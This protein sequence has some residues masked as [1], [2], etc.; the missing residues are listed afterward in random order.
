MIRCWIIFVQRIIKYMV[1]INDF[2]RAYS[3]AIQD[4]YAAIFAGA[5]L[6]MSCGFVDWKGLLC[7]L[8]KEIKL[9]VEKEH[10][11]VEVAQYYC[12]EKRG[13][14]EISQKILNYF[15][16]ETE[17]ESKENE[18]VRLLAELPIKTFWTTNY[19]H[20]IEDT[21]KKS[22]K[23]VDIK[24][25]TQSLATTLSGSDAIVY[26]MHGDYLNA[27][28][29]VI[30]KDDYECYNDTRQLFSTTLQGDLVSKTFLFIG[31]S[32]EDPNLNYILSRI[33]V[34]LDK[35][36]RT[37]YL[38]SK[39]INKNDYE[40]INDYVYAQN[41]Q[42]LK[43]HDLL[44]YGIETVLIDDYSEIPKILSDLKIM[45][46]CNNIFISGSAHKYG[47]KWEKTAPLF[48]RELVHALYK[49]D[50]KIIT[51][52]ARGIGSYVISSVL[53]E[54]QSSVIELEKHLMI[55]AFPYEDKSRSDY[56]KIIEGYRKG[57][58]KSAGIAIFMFGNKTINNNTVLADGVYKEYQIAKQSG[59]Y[60]IPIGSTGYM[61]K[62]IWSEVYSDINNYPYLKKHI[63]V[64]QECTEPHT[65]IDSIISILEE[66]RST[67]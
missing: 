20:L 30:I 19:D 13:R 49:K 42:E 33:R 40:K 43:M 5:G 45:N 34:L 60:I 21:L 14:N 1:T 9:D 39:K 29:C 57:I 38:F 22:G 31:F 56:D 7:D 8:A 66:I 35:N 25:T 3:K 36:R 63:S 47:V 28:E 54:C 18:N 27:S 52:H 65:V 62:Q 2:K 24:M 50:Y 17:S 32:F 41:K 12:N 55:K 59:A 64:L 37:H 4:G 26:K 6:S 51:G 58:F 44:R 61:A 53:E 10:D 11:L 48:I 23:L 16:T 67:F 46:K 15:V